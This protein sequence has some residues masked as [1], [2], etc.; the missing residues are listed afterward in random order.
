MARRWTCGVSISRFATGPAGGLTTLIARFQI[1][2]EWPDCTNWDG[3]E[4]GEFPQNIEWADSIG[5]IQESGRN[6]VGPGETLTET[7]YFIVLQG[8][9]PPQFANWAMDFDF[10][11]Q[12][13]ASRLPV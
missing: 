3:P 2:S 5:H 11:R 7:K 4:A 12:S 6:V 8:D 10:C 9:P 1:E 13:A